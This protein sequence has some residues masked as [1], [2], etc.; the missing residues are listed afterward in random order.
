MDNHV[1]ISLGVGDIEHAKRFYCDG[2]GFELERAAGPFAAFKQPNGA[3]GLALYSGDPLD[4][5]A[6]VVEDRGGY[7]GVSLAYVVDAPERVDELMARAERA[8]ATILEP[9]HSADW[10]GYLGYFIDPDG[11]FWKIVVGQTG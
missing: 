2:L 11:N 4:Y 5:D 3:P 1:V 7:R 8:G 9:A 10:G 6:R